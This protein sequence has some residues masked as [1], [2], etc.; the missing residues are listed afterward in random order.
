MNLIE[1]AEATEKAVQTK[2]L[3]RDKGVATLLQIKKGEAL[4]E[5]ESMTN[6]LL[7]LLSGEAVYEEADRREVLARS[8]DFVRIPAKTTHKVM[9]VEDAVL[10]L[11]Q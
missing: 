8:L 5:H 6:A 7:V 3:L 10:M 1:L 11:I 9:G 2:N 4:R